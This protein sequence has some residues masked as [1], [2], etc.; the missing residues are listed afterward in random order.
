MKKAEERN[1][2]VGVRVYIKSNL[3]WINKIS[4]VK[5]YGFMEVENVEN[6]NLIVKNNE[7]NFTWYAI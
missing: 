5:V 6:V 3:Y 7:K 4:Y 2:I 1:K